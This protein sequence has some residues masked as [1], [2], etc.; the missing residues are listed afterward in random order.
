MVLIPGVAF[1]MN[2]TIEKVVHGPRDLTTILQGAGMENYY[3]FCL[4]GTN[5]ATP[6]EDGYIDKHFY[7]VMLWPNGK[8]S[9]IICFNHNTYWLPTDGDF[10]IDNV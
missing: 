9:T 7:E 4:T 8:V 1:K 10:K 5:V 3:T 2:A 6:L